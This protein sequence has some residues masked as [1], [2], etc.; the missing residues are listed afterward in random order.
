MT[1]L[2]KP[3]LCGYAGPPSALPIRM[4]AI[5]ML[6]LLPLLLALPLAACETGDDSRQAPGE[7]FAKDTDVRI[8]N[9]SNGET[10]SIT[11]RQNDR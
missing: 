3:G 4:P 6:K 9:L 7:D 11:P 2:R 1:G 10:T 5:P 8:T